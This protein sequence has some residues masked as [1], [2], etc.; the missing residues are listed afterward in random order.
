L[1]P[2]QAA[3][4]RTQAGAAFGSR[5]KSEGISAIQPRRLRA[6]SAHGLNRLIKELW[7]MSGDRIAV[8][9]AYE[10]HASKTLQAQ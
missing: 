5:G 6:G 1:P 9:F 4:Q 8:R 10:W 2:E 3:E 7:A